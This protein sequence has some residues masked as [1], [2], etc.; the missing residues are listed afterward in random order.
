MNKKN[1]AITLGSI[2]II[3]VCIVGLFIAIPYYNVWQQEMSGRAEFAKAEQNRKIKIEEA[4]AN[5]EAEKLNAQAEIERAKGAAE[6]IR[7]ENGSLTPS[8]IQYLWV[9]QQSNLN[10]KTVIYIP[11]EANLPILEANRNK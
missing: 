3:L 11:T 8:Y 4:K 9:R 7:I 2:V 10:D 6:A 1:L 5:L